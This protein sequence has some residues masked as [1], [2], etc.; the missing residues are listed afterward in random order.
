MVHVTST[1]DWLRYTSRWPGDVI[2]DDKA[3]GGV[4]RTRVV[5]HAAVMWDNDRVVARNRGY[6]HARGLN[7]AVVEWH[8]GNPEQGIGV[9]YNGS[10]LYALS[11]LGI[12]PIRAL[13]HAQHIDAAVT[14]LDLAIDIR[15]HATASVRDVHNAW[16]AGE[17]D[18]RVRTYS[19]WTS[20]RDGIAG[21]TVYIGSERSHKRLV[22]YNKAAQQGVNGR[23]IRCEIR[24]RKQA[25]RAAATAIL[26]GQPLGSVAASLMNGVATMPTVPWY[27]N[28]LDIAADGVIDAIQVKRKETDTEA[29]LLETIIPLLKRTYND[30]QTSDTIKQAIEEITQCQS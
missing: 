25:A 16:T 27:G 11:E 20:E 26:T 7:V 6:T 30:D 24:L 1:I 3:L 21:E 9:T 2:A 12:G 17:I 29:W 18:T 10:D 5:P 22:V 23:W 8:H 19:H 15:D 28:A 4:L 13:Q 14:R